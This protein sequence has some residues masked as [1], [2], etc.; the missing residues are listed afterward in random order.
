MMK[1]VLSLVMALA[2]IF[3]AAAAMAESTGT[4]EGSG[5]LTFVSTEPNTLNMIQSAS[6]LDA[7]V[8]YLT[9]AMLYRPYNGSSYPELAESCVVNETNTV[10][11]YTIKDAVYTDG[12]KITA[13]DFVY[14]L[15]NKLDATS[16]VYYKNGVKY[17][18]GECTVA[19]L[20]IYAVDE[21]TFVVELEAATADFDPQLEIYPLN[22]AFVEAKGDALGG[23]PA[24]MMYSGPYVLTEWV[25]GSYLT[26][27]KNPTYINAAD[28][29]QIKDLK[30]IHSVDES[31][32]YAMFAA[33]EVDL[34]VTV[35]ESTVEQI[36]DKCHYNPGSAIQGLEFNTKG[37][38]FDGSTF[39]PRDPAV[40]A[41]LANKNFRMALSYAINRDLIVPVVNG[42]GTAST[43]VINADVVGNTAD[44]K[45]VDDYPSTVIPG[46]GDE[47]LA[48]EYME[49]AL[50]ELGYKSVSELPTIKYLTFD[51]NMYR[52][53][54]EVLQ[55][56]WKRVLGLECIQIE[57]KPVSD[58][59]MSMVFMDYDIYY[60]SLTSTAD[61][62]RS[63]LEFWITGGSV[64][65]V[66]QAGAPFSSIYS[67]PKFDELVKNAMY[68]FD[69]VKRN[70]MMAE[71]EQLLLESYIFV[72]IQWN[73]NYY[74]VSDR[75]QGYVQNES[76][77]GIMIN[78]ATVTE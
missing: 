11:T 2:M 44:S 8:F 5:S 65:D 68:E 16:A 75:L 6:N 47:A 48:K 66:M 19:D 29:F 69:P 56:E 31:G 78:Y 42:S 49:K 57:L 10:Y 52:L 34:M 63:F 40:T 64:S 23:T 25:Y 17:V 55:S 71:A 39:A 54:A 3:T 32:R 50:A 60:Q 76:Q 12:S 35:G 67:D 72:P 1:R 51:S 4:V 74:A 33:G 26:F 70:A 46:A 36:P 38:Y 43:R 14:Y 37:M 58:A 18:N 41:V 13:A 28:S 61:A 77:D 9:S 20:G 62:P 7:D 15:I 45:F 21:K 73:G 22:Q 59:V 53:T 27:T 24:D 30:M